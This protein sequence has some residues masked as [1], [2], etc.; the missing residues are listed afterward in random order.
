MNNWLKIG[1]PIL[2]AVL[3][4]AAS[5]GIT[6]AVTKTNTVGAP[7]YATGNGTGPGYAYGPRYA[8]CPAWGWTQSNAQGS[9]ETGRWAGCHGYWQ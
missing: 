2:I 5:V 1:L 3:L 9:T 6:L 8:S 4:V 7:T